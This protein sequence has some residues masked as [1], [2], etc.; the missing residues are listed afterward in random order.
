M[1]ERA[2]K[3]WSYWRDVH[4]EFFTNLCEHIGRTPSETMPVVCSSF[5]L[6]EDFK[7]L[8]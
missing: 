4:W 1:K 3:H 5:E 2:T 8:D 6:V 7:Q